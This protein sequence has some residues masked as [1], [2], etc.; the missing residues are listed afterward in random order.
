MNWRRFFRRAEADADLRQE[1]ESY[2]EITTDEYVARGMD[3]DAARAAACRKLGNSTLVREE[4]YY[5]NTI[6][7]VESLSAALRY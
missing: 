2:L 1:L 7:F 3:P 5:T 4:V 6:P